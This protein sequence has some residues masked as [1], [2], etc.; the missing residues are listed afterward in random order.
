MDYK[1]IVQRSIDYIEENLKTKLTT[2]ELAEHAGFSLFHYYRVFQQFTGMPVMQYIVRRR[3]AH[4]I[5]I[6]G[7]FISTTPF[8]LFLKS[9]KLIL[10]N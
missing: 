4:A 7:M 9:R 10:S 8:I 2:D 6:S 3:L 1:H 5:I